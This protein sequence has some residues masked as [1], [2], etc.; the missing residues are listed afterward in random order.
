MKTMRMKLKR[1][2]VISKTY[3]RIMDFLKVDKLLTM[4][5]LSVK[6]FTFEVIMK[7]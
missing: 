5:I 1:S 4:R 3:N 2:M 7:G 6:L